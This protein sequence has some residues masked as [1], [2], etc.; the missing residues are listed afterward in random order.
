MPWALGGG[1][2]AQAVAVKAPVNYDTKKL[3]PLAF[4][5]PPV[6]FL[7]GNLRGRGKYFIAI[8]WPSIFNAPLF[9]LRRVWV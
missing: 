4:F 5:V 2:L 8:K 7:H 9:P 6:P 1:R 3:L